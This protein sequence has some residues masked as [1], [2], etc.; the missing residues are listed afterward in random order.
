[1]AENASIDELINWES[2]YRERLSTPVKPCGSHKM[3]A[4][5]PFHAEKDPSFWFNTENGLWKCEAGCG[6]GNA[7][8]FL[9][10]LEGISTAEAYKKLL[11]LAGIDDGE[12]RPQGG[13]SKITV[14]SY[15]L[16]KRFPEEFLL[17]LGVRNSKNG[18]YIAIPYYDE[19]MRIIAT[20]MRMRPGA[21]PRFKWMRGAAGVKLYG[22]WKLQEARSAGY[23]VIVEGESDAQTLWLHGIPAVGIPGAT[24]FNAEYAKLLLDIPKAYF[25]QEPD[26][27]GMAARKHIAQGLV[28]AEYTGA[29]YILSCGSSG[30]KDPSELY[31]KLG[32]AFQATFSEL[33]ATAEQVNPALACV[34]LPDGLDDA[35][36][37]FVVPTGYEITQNGI[38]QSNKQGV[39][40]D[41]PFTWTPILISKLLPASLGDV[42][43]ELSFKVN[44]KWRTSV[45]KRSV[46]A[47]SRSIVNLSDFGAD[48]TSE[49]AGAVVKWL[50]AF[51]QA[52]RAAIP[53]ARR[54]THYG[55]ITDDQF[56]PGICDDVYFDF[57]EAGKSANVGVGKGSFDEWLKAMEPHR[58]KS[59]V[60]RFILAAAFAAPLIKPF[61]QRI[62]MVY[63]WGGSK[64]GKT[65]ALK[66]ALSAWGDPE[67]MMIDFGATKVGLE[68][69]AAFFC[70]L[71]LGI[72][73]RQLAGS[74]QEWLEGLVYMLSEGKGRIRGNKDGGLREQKTWRTVAIANGEESLSASTSQ[75]GVNT[76]VIEIYGKPFEIEKEAAEM[77]DTVLAHHGHAGPMFVKWFVRFNE[78]NPGAIQKMFDEIRA[79]VASLNRTSASKNASI[80]LIGTADFIYSL[81]FCKLEAKDALTE[82]KAMISAVISDKTQETDEEMDVN[83]QA[84]EFIQNWIASNAV[85]FT[86]NFRRERLGTF[87]T[88]VIDDAT[89]A[90][91]FPASL[92]KALVGRGYAYKKTLRWMA[93]HGK[94]KTTIEGD[95][96]IRN[97]VTKRF[98]GR[99]MRMVEIALREDS[100]QKTF[101]ID[102]L[103]PVEHDDQVPF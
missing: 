20:R 62:F 71:P 39:L 72:N 3:H 67:S 75:T 38:Y 95:N 21:S 37:K 90:W 101:E 25:H 10:R 52:N 36:V 27:G 54:I 97:T 51:E 96:K 35:P 6:S 8:S 16:Q 98:Q 4:C 34:E 102:E 88:N 15:A 89:K 66:A 79:H 56:Y 13:T 1:M 81:I 45:V 84:Y 64:G 68:N 57:A 24:T 100:E 49:N 73:E 103:T 46:I 92:E 80:A 86:D 76:R 65:A 94:I 59:P 30:A 17:E 12:R 19:N 69:S 63:N 70:D 55:W 28:D 29:F 61:Y 44:D 85:E 99:P 93:E 9:A 82:T 83:L 42:K 31:A 87:D 33:L 77:Y 14:K 60:F 11:G 78:R 32:D 40:E 47:T 26:K 50:S 91:I 23:V 22:V 74:K 2:F 7:T 5:C 18:E 53:T 41:T 48:V 58:Q 43:V